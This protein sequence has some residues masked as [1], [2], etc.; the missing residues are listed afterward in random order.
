MDVSEEIDVN[1]TNDLHK[2]IICNFCY[3]L[4]INFRFLPKL[5]NGY[6]DLTQKENE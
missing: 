4:K 3:C 2:C 6:H 1:K 5:S